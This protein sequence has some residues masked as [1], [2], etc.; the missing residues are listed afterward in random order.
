MYR[1]LK[2]PRPASPMPE[3]VVDYS[4]FESGPDLTFSH[5]AGTLRLREPESARNG[6]TIVDRDA[7]S[8]HVRS[9][10]ARV[11]DWLLHSGIQLDSGPQRG[12]VAGWLDGDGQPEFVYLEIT[13][14]YLTA[15]AWLASGAAS[16]PEHRAAAQRRARRAARWIGSLV[17]G[18]SAPPTRLY[19]SAHHP[20]WRNNAV[21]S[22][23]LAMAARGMAATRRLAGWPEQRA[24]AEISARVDRISSGAEVMVSHELVV[25]DAT[26]MPDRWSTRPCAHHLKAAAAM[27]GLPKRVAGDQAIAMARRTYDHWADSLASDKWPCEEL[28]AVL[29]ALE[30]MLLRASALDDLNV[31]ERVFARLMELQASDGSL[32]ETVA[33][34]PARSDVLAQALRVALLLRGRQYLSEPKWTDRIDLLTRALLEYIRPDGGVGF[35]HEQPISNAWCAMFAHQA[36]YL[37]ACEGSLPPAAYDL[38]V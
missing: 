34:G 1:A 32:P 20:D 29:Y 16:S 4:R 10:V 31:A 35:S 24:L 6:M 18:E 28:H 22:F 30:G 23:D 26:T 37:R 5:A 19:L 21:F 25:G 12:G 9:A 38:L 36:L 13:G 17:E 7:P 27:L 33:G 3:R 15:M 14:Y 2:K 11:E 8:S